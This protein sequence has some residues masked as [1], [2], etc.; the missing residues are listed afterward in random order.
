MLG[1]DWL[2]YTPPSP[3]FTDVNPGDWHYAYIETAVSHG[4]VSGY[5]DGTFRPNNSVTRGQ[6]AKMIVL[7]SALLIYT[8]PTPSFIDVPP[9]HTFYVY[10]ETARYYGLISGYGDGTY[11]PN[12]NATRGQL[13]K[14]LYIALTRN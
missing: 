8:P 1:E 11:R 7:A 12:Y 14:I 5:P 9:T 4:V 10:I 13:C 2:L 3:S 6:L